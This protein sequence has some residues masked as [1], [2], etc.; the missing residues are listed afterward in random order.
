MSEREVVGFIGLGLMG[1]PM[2]LNLIKAGYTLVVHS[3]S[4]GPV[5]SLALAGAQVA[6]SPADVA[7]EATV[8]ITMV[9]AAP[10]WSWCSPART[11]CSREC[12]RARC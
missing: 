8:V 5:E 11:A 4:R 7:R 6:G 1:R 3:R 9:P 2:A 12:A 10:T